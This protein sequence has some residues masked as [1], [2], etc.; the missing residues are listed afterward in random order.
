MF[1]SPAF[2]VFDFLFGIPLIHDIMF[3]IYRKQI[4]EKAGQKIKLSPEHTVLSAFMHNTT[5]CSVRVW[6]TSIGMVGIVILRR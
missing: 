5:M 1:E 4:V 2:K 3:G 6:F